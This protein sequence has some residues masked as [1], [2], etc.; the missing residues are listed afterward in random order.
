MTRA[1]RLSRFGG[2]EVLGLEHVEVGVPGAGQVR[3]EHTAIGLNMIDTYCRSGLYPLELPGGLGGE[4]AGV[5][6]AVGPDVAGLAPGDRVAYAAPAP[7]DAYAEARLIDARWLVRLPDAID[8]TT[9]AAVMLK[10]LTSW[11][12]LHRSYRAAAGDWLLVHAGAGGVGSLLTQWAAA[13]GARV[14]GIVGSEAKRSLALGYGAA[15]VLLASEPVPERVRELT[16]GA[17]VAAVYDSVGRDTFTAS[18]DCLRRHGVMVSYGNS[19]GP[20]EPFA[21]LELMRRGS[22]YV[23]R[24]V[25]FDFIDARAEL[26]AASALLFERII[27]GSIAVDVRQ[28]FALADAADA[29]RALEA[30][31]TTGASVLL[32]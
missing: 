2:P 23:T 26:E 16:G 9:A 12:L 20:V 18:L 29:H 4:A 1:I 25:L 5:V 6:R 10:G 28:R 19:S 7:F 11:F 22:L 17:G 8:D 21:P 32:P 27:D 15:H 31:R 13:L 24:P 30:R 3:V 14:I